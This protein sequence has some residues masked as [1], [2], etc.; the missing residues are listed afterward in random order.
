MRWRAD[1]KSKVLFIYCDNNLPEPLS[2]FEEPSLYLHA[3]ALLIGSPPAA[4]LGLS[5]RASAE[6]EIAKKP[7][8]A[9]FM[10]AV[11]SGKACFRWPGERLVWEIGID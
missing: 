9:A 8:S 3:F 6:K 11:T 5:W 2:S 1:Q 10:E 4:S 7:M